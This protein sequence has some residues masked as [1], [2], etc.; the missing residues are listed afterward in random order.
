VIRAATQEEI[1]R[2]AELI[3]YQPTVDARGVAYLA[4]G[5]EEPGAMVIYDRWSHN[6][7]EAHVW[8][9]A[10]G[11][12]FD[13]KYLQAI[14]EYPFLQCGRGVVVAV[15]PSDSAESLALSMA[16]GF[17]ESYR[18]RDYWKPGVDMVIKEMRKEE[19][20]WLETHTRTE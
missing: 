6:G 12:F 1:S 3:G 5:K 2:V 20:K 8:S 16:L 9:C 4:E 15:T 13:K 11:A 19:C 17:R 18:V 10:P 14:F 7:A